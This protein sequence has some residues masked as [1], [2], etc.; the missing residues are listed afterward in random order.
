MKGNWKFRNMDKSEKLIDPIQ[1]QFFTTNIVGGLTAAL[2]RETIQNSLDA[3]TKTKDENGNDYIVSIRF[4]LSGKTDAVEPQKANEYLEE[5]IPHLK[6]KNNGIVSE[7][8]PDFNKPMPYLLIEDYSTVGLE[9]DPL[10]YEDP[11][12][13]TVSH[14]FFWFWRNVGRSGK[15]NDAR[16]RWGLGKAVFPKSSKI[17]S[18]F[19]FTLRESDERKLLMG[20]SILKIHKVEGEEDNSYP[21]G[22]YGVFEDEKSDHFVSPIEDQT[23]IDKLISDFDLNRIDENGDFY[24]GLSLLIPYPYDEI[25]SSEL[26]KT[27]VHQ[28]FYP[29]IN[30]QLTVE[31][32]DDQLDEPEILDN[33]NIFNIVDS[34]KFSEDQKHFKNN[35]YKL[36][37]FV[38][39]ILNIDKAEYLE[40]REPGIE[41]EPAWSKAYLLDDELDKQL[42]KLKDKFDLGEKVA[43]KVPVKITRKNKNPKISFFH[44]YMEKDELLEEPDCHFIRDGITI[45]GVPAPRRKNLRALV[46]VEDSILSDL[47]GDAENPAH[48]EW[49]KDSEKLYENYIGGDKVVSFIM[50]SIDR[51]YAWLLKPVEGI[52]KNILEE[53]FYLEMDEE[54][55]GGEDNDTDEPG[56]DNPDE[57]TIP[58][59]PNIQPISITK[60]NNGIQVKQNDRIEELPDNIIL[61]LG[62]MVPRGNAIKKYNILDFEL[63]KDPIQVDSK[64]VDIIQMEK[65]ILEFK[66][67]DKNFNLKITGFDTSR[68]LIVESK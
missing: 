22:Y 52:D 14:N 54:Q 21:Y 9:G 30:K 63:D 60:I 46:I 47:L 58:R 42:D 7:S 15:G 48:T 57:P 28:Y 68:D 67:L 39:W 16:G 13:S 17:N 12:D 55:D 45:L 64:Y 56:D 51:L 6:A 35:L 2:V 61:K 44:V 34:I 53:Y 62:Y 20:E 33:E 36:F 38:Q 18:F 23:F 4:K 31:F 1:N 11:E 25:T 26:I 49:S 59:K 65:N 10:E 19:G 27:T 3:K 40:L 50:N 37:E 8:L 43:F 24:F 29:I 5:L 66:A 41:Y 32:E